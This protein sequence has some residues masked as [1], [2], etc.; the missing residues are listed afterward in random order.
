[1]NLAIIGCGAIAEHAHLP[2]TVGFDGIRVSTLIDTDLVRA[3]SLAERYGVPQV[4]ESLNQLSEQP[5]AAIVALPHHLHAEVAIAFLQRGIHVLVEK[6]MALST[7]ECDEMIGA[8]NRGKAV[9]AVGMV[10]RFLPEFRLAQTVLDG[11]E[12]GSIQSF[13]VEE[14]RIYDWKSAT[15]SF[16]HRKTAG[17]GVLA[18]LGVHV[19]DGLLGWLGEIRLVEYADDSY[20]GVEAEAEVRLAF[21]S[22][23]IGSV[24]LSRTRDLRNTTLIRGSKAALEVDL[25]LRRIALHVNGAATHLENSPGEFG[26]DIF[27]AQLAD[28]VNAIR[29]GQPPT[30]DGSEGRRS[31]AMIENCYAN[32][33]LLEFPWVAP[34]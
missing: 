29:T 21:G 9:L 11:G 10:R 32:R 4:A 7:A 19:L 33:R 28:F 22:S 31:V 26:H 1:M 12:L 17:G 6:P 14:G 16:L 8:A 27:R 13:E 23:G 30:V 20:G 2:A 18:D 15:D 24:E 25:Y 3:R 34:V 5:D